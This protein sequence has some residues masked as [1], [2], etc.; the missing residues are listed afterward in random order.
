[1]SIQPFCFVEHLP[2]EVS[3]MIFGKL[4]D[5]DS[6]KNAALVSRQWHHAVDTSK[7]TGRGEAFQ[8]LQPTLKKVCDAIAESCKVSKQRLENFSKNPKKHVKNITLY[9]KGQIAEEEKKWLEKFLDKASQQSLES[10]EIKLEDTSFFADLPIT[11]IIKRKLKT[12]TPCKE[13]LDLVQKRLG[14][15]ICPPVLKKFNCTIFSIIKLFPYHGLF[16]LKLISRNYNN[17]FPLQIIKDI[18]KDHEAKPFGDDIL[19]VTVHT[20]PKAQNG[21][22]VNWTLP[23]FLADRSQRVQDH[24]FVAHTKGPFLGSLLLNRK[25]NTQAYSIYLWL[26]TFS[27]E[28]NKKFLNFSYRVYVKVC[29]IIHDHHSSFG[30][31]PEKP[32]LSSKCLDFYKHMAVKKLRALEKK[33]KKIEPAP[34]RE[35]LFI[36]CG[37]LN[38]Q[39]AELIQKRVEANQWV[40]SLKKEREIKN[41][42]QEFITLAKRYRDA[43]KFE[44]LLK[45]MNF[46]N[47]SDQEDFVKLFSSI[48]GLCDRSPQL[49]VKLIQKINNFHRMS[50]TANGILHSTKNYFVAQHLV[51]THTEDLKS[52]L[53]FLKEFKLTKYEKFHI[54]IRMLNTVLR[55]QSERLAKKLLPLVMALMGV[56]PLPSEA[57]LPSPEVGEGKGEESMEVDDGCEKTYD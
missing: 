52:Q 9:R 20:T 57:Q 33:Q 35:P 2:L 54:A 47:Y 31:F 16:L 23:T 46:L 25:Y 45:L 30:F 27:R 56:S 55:E 38:P 37:D 7:N 53:D 51:F 5:D 40:N 26:C 43:S 29:Q 13:L 3:C 24:E 32:E 10:L 17:D 4:D 36:E 1:M 19:E 42:N 28:E 34:P 49:V 11:I 15:S 21:K 22:Y 14:K 41:L 44:D 48:L 39:V 8:Y 6:M 12:K 50:M 18:D